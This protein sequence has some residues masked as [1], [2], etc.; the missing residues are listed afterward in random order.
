VKRL[1]S[2][3]ALLLGSA[4]A[5]EFAS[6]P[7]ALVRSF[8]ADYAA[9]NAQSV[10]RGFSLEALGRSEEEYGALIAK[11][12]RPG[13][14]HQPVTYGDDSMH[15]VDSERVVSVEEQ[16]GKAL[17]RTRH[18][19]KHAKGE[20]IADFEYQLSKDASRWYLEGVL[21]VDSKGKYEGL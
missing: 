15:E 5:S 2:T 17:V 10:K 6:A 11:Y 21:Y 18:T 16:G 20:F 1:L 3:L 19:S 14:K 9:W 12:C 8:I 4:S 13:F 7:D